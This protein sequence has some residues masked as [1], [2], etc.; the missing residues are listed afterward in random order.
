MYDSDINTI[1][2]F[3]D[4]LCSSFQTFTITN[5]ISLQD[6][7]VK[8]IKG[9]SCMTPFEYASEW[10]WCKTGPVSFMN[11]IHNMDSDILVT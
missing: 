8:T 10:W 9:E 4:L 11:S 2:W 5:L 6:I 1:V 7:V 3:Y